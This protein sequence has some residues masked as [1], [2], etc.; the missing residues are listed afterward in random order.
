MYV[1]W[2]AHVNPELT[3]RLDEDLI[4]EAKRRAAARGVS[5]SRLV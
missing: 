5:L 4:R 3:L 1:W 2:E